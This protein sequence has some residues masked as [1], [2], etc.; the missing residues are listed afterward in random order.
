[1]YAADPALIATPIGT[2]RVLGSDDFL[3]SIAIEPSSGEN[4]EGEG[5]ATREAAQQLRAYFAARLDRF[6]LPLARASTPRSEALRTA[7][8][9]IPRGETRTYGRLAAG[10]ASSARAIGAVCRTNAFPIVVPCHRVVSAGATAFYSAGAGPA[11]KAWLLAHERTW[12]P[13]GSAPA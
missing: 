4:R 11:T 1:M 6:D 13:P 2:I 8:V 3:L 10:H 7:L 12:A 5:A 9:A